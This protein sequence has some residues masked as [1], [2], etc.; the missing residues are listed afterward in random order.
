[1]DKAIYSLILKQADKVEYISGQYH[2]GC[3][4]MRN[5]RLVEISGFCIC[6]MTRPNS[7]TAFT[8]NYAQ[9]KGLGI[10]NLYRDFP[11]ISQSVHPT[12]TLQG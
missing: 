1:M 2:P 5:R 8:V 4:F 6:Y 11:L 3:M 10:V 9:D 12:N 7:G